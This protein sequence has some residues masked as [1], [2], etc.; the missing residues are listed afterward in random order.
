MNHEQLDETPHPPLSR[1]LPKG[2]AAPK[3]KD[4]ATGTGVVLKS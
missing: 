1:T 3:R 4:G 2:A